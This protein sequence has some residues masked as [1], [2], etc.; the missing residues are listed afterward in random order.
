MEQVVVK[1]RDKITDRL[2]GMLADIRYLEHD[3]QAIAIDTLDRCVAQCA[4]ILTRIKRL[5]RRVYVPL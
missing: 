1:E 3:D 2:E 5:R 4:E